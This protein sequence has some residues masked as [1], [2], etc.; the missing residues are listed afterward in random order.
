MDDKPLLQQFIE[1]GRDLSKFPNITRVHTLDEIE[2]G[3]TV[4]ILDDDNNY[5]IISEMVTG[6]LQDDYLPLRGGLKISGYYNSS[7]GILEQININRIARE[8]I[9]ANAVEKGRVYLVTS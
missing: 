1:S 2:N 6:L 4:W 5:H 3:S 7:L 9:L 8:H